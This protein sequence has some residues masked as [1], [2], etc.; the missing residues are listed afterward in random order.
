[1]PSFET[2]GPVALDVDI[3]SGDVTVRTWTAQVLESE[4]YTER[5]YERIETYCTAI[6]RDVGRII[7][8]S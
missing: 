8:E 6:D 5:L 2:P 1:M 4:L 7:V 3:P